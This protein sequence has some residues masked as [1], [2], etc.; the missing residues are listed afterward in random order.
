MR[1]EETWHQAQSTCCPDHTLSRRTSRVSTKS[2]RIRRVAEAAS[3]ESS[4]ARKRTTLSAS[5]SFSSGFGVDA[6]YGRPWT[7]AQTVAYAAIDTYRVRL[8][9]PLLTMSAS[10]ASDRCTGAEAARLLGWKEGK[11][12]NTRRS[13]Q[14]VYDR[15]EGAFEDYPSEQIVRA[16]YRQAG[17]P[18]P[19]DSRI[20]PAQSWYQSTHWLVVPEWGGSKP[21]H[22]RWSYSRTLLKSFRDKGPSALGS[23]L[24]VA[25]TR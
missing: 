16:L 1:P 19:E 9:H 6:S 21:P 7:E 23:H 15:R 17:S 8:S 14:M 20:D 22:S 18:G 13:L 4:I 10:P 11:F 3:E 12:N 25:P 5:S 2:A 24:T